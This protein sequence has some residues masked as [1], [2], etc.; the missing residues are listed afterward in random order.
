MKV[1]CAGPIFP[2]ALL[3][4][5]IAMEMAIVVSVNIIL[6]QEIVKSFYPTDTHLSTKLPNKVENGRA[7]P[8]HNR[9]RT[10]WNS[11][12]VCDESPY[13]RS[14]DDSVKVW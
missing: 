4:L 12:R 9:F 7:Q 11:N 1:T 8:K 2:R 10:C 13:V 14:P 3:C 5:L 6:D